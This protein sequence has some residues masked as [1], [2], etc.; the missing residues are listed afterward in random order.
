LRQ[1]QFENFLEQKTEAISFR[2]TYRKEKGNNQNLQH[3]GFVRSIRGVDT[4]YIRKTTRYE[5]LNIFVFVLENIRTHERLSDMFEMVLRFLLERNQECRDSLCVEQALSKEG[6][7]PRVRSK[8]T[9]S[10][11]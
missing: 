2:A 6:K 7:K 4:Q 9:R 10:E 5:K 1:D 11:P 8:E 3:F